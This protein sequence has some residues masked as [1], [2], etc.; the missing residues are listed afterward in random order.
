MT[1]LTVL[2]SGDIVAW[3]R[4]SA[5]VIDEHAAELTELDAAIGD[6]DHGENMRR[7]LTAAVEAID[8]AGGAEGLGSPDAVLKKV[9]LTL[10]SKVGGASGPLYGTMFLRMATSTAGKDVLDPAAFNEAV[11]AGVAGIVQ[12]GHAAVGE[13]TMIDAWVPALEAARRSGDDLL[14]SATSAAIAAEAGREATRDMVATKGR[15]SYLGT[16]SVGH[17][18]PG[19]ASSALIIRALHDVIAAGGSGEAAGDGDAAEAAL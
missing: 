19:A 5:Q 14:A 10:I 12:R 7:G 17:I 9:A 13:K 16:R 15:A 1:A 11:E 4:L 18:D 6:A 3:V 2:G 8:E